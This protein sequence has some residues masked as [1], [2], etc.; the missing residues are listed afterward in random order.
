MRAVLAMDRVRSALRGGVALTACLVAISPAAAQTRPVGSVEVTTDYRQRGISWS[1]GRAAAS[2]ALGADFGGGFRADAAATTLRGTARH[3]GA[4]A[5]LDLSAG[6]RIDRGALWLDGGVVGHVFPGG[7]GARD[8][9]EVQGAVS[10]LI[11]PADLTL[12]ADYAPDQAAIGG[13]N[14]YVRAGARVAV[15]GSPVTLSAHVGR[16]SGDADG[17]GRAWRLRP[18]GRYYDWGVAADYVL[19]RITLRLAYSD[20]DIRERAG[21]ATAHSG[22]VVVGSVIAAF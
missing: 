12:S 11:G 9:A 5:G 19:Q 3:G 17:S 2:A 18:D 10:T 21:P 6:Y 4:D 15:V 8:Y 14:L 22:A 1:G 20:T 16:S 7:R 13:D